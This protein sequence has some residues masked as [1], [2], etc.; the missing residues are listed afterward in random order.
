M[1]NETIFYYVTEETVTESQQFL[2]KRFWQ[3]ISLESFV[4]EKDGMRV[5]TFLIPLLQKGWKKEKLLRVMQESA[6]KHP[7]YAGNVRILIQPG[8]Q[9]FSQNDTFLSICLS[10][11]EKILRE[12][13]PVQNIKDGPESVVLLAGRL[14]FPE[15][16]IRHF[17]EM[18]RPYLPRVNALTVFY[19][20]E[21]MRGSGE[22]IREEERVWPFHTGKTAETEQL[23]EVIREYTDEL[24]YE[25]GLVCQVI[26]GKEIRYDKY[27]RPN[28]QSRTLFLDYGYS[29]SMP[30]YMLKSGG[31]YLDIASS[32]EK[33]ALFRRKYRG[34]FYQSPR[35]YLD[36]AV[37]SGYDK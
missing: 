6:E 17:A 12:Q 1:G 37:K 3:K 33:E 27:C 16:Q 5:V 31:V 28:G 20:A 13:F 29:G 7:L 22:D 30:F 19:E 23:K 9:F 14:F 15:E 2:K 34:I 10:F 32:E 4:A 35:K 25:Y 26:G 36:T 24:Y 21:E 8:L 18:I 11:A